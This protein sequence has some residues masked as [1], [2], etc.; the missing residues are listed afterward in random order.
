[1]KILFIIG[2]FAIG[3]TNAKPTIEAEIDTIIELRDSVE[4][5]VKNVVEASFSKAAALSVMLNSSIGNIFN[6]NIPICLHFTQQFVYILSIKI[7]IFI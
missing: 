1:M 4:E 2:V 3:L 7:P 6:N 5:S